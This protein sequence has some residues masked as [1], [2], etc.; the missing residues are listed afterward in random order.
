MKKKTREKM[1]ELGAFNKSCNEVEI[2][3]TVFWLK[4]LPVKGKG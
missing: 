4:M 2:V 3:L 1:S